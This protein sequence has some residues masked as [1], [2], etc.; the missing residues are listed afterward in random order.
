MHRVPPTPWSVTG[1]LAL[2]DAALSRPPAEP[3]IERVPHRGE[4]VARFVLPLELCQPV[5]RTRHVVRWKHA[6]RKRAIRQLMAIQH[7][8]QGGGRRREPLPGRPL[9]RA[10]R[11]SSVPPD[12][13][14]N[15]AKSAIDVLTVK[16]GLGYLRDDGRRYCDQCE[17]WE[18]APAGGGCVLV[19]VWSG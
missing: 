12:A 7:Y 10:V 4:C 15:T 19:E 3:W 16:G 18:P 13:G 6:R 11:F 8:G 5:N 14:A 17:W 2:A 9:I 1:A